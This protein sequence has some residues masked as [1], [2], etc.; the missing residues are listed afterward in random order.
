MSLLSRHAHLSL[1]CMRQA[2]PQVFPEGWSTADAAEWG[3]NQLLDG[4]R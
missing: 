3:V 1:A 4:A 2:A